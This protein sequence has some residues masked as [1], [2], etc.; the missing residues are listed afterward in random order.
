MWRYILPVVFF[1]PSIAA[2]EDPPDHFTVGEIRASLSW[3]SISAMETGVLRFGASAGVHIK[4]GFEIG[5]EQ[6]FIV[7]PK[8]GRESRSWSYIRIVPFR[9]WVVSPFIAARA[10]YY[11]MSDHNAF[12]L[13]AG[14]GAVMFIDRHF[15]FEASLYT[16]GV[17]SQA[18]SPLSENEFDWR[19][20]VFF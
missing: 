13:G 16:Q 8:S 7:P 11:L 17:F 18:V 20:I 5:A 1:L 19:M 2:A 14:L 6:Q 9:D 15:A 4:D 3:D 10:G 12:G